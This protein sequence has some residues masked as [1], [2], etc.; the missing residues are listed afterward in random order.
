MKT[1]MPKFYSLANIMKA[2][3]EAKYYMVYGQRS[4]GK[5]FSVLEYGLRKYLESGEQTAIIRRF[6]EDFMGGNADDM[7]KNFIHNEWRGN[8]IEE[9]S[10]GEWN[11]VKYEKSKWY[12]EHINEDGETDKKDPNPFAYRFAL[13]DEE[14]K[15]GTGYPLITT[16]L[17]DEF[18]TRSYYLPNEFITFMNILSTVIRLRDNAKIFM[19]ANTI[20]KY[21]L[22]FNEMG[23]TR[24]KNQKQGTIDVYEYGSS[25]LQVA[26]EYSEFSAKAKK[27][28]IYFAFDNPKLKM[29]TTGE[30][31]ISLY[32]HCPVDYFPNEVIYQYFI[33]FDNEILHCEIINHKNHINESKVEEQLFTFVHRKTTPI[34]DDGVCMVFQDK[35]EP[36]ANYARK[37]NKPTTPI[38][39]KIWWFYVADKI[40]YQDNSV[41]ETMRNYLEWCNHESN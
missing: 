18:I 4:N 12:L 38:Q 20:N 32:P 3:P 1:K 8:V 16:I 29:I 2:A 13:T 24:V 11:F 39:K 10:K 27:S 19:C 21:S 30:W 40:Y 6:K 37:I 36:K 33:V 7:F 35:N 31:E 9:L 28:D 34:K 15:K 5:T 22:Y 14:H 41:G 26:V 23:L 25:G 17:F